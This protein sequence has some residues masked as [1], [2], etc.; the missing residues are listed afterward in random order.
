MSELGGVIDESMSSGEQRIT[1][2]IN[3]SMSH[4]TIMVLG[5]GP[6][7]AAAALGLHKLGYVVT[8]ISRP[9]RPACIEGI[10][11]RVY[12]ALTGLGLANALQSISAP[13]PRRV[14][15]NGDASAANTE[16]LI[17]RR[18]ESTWCK[19]RLSDFLTAMRVGRLC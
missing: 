7:G 19:G 15:W 4:S 10:S 9:R 17:W 8:C 6:A 13:V 12:A 5:A 16:R 3:E 14:I 2:V 1:R 18:R 11:E